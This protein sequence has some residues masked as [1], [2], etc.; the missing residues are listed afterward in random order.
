[1]DP[2]ERRLNWIE[3]TSIPNPSF[4]AHEKQHVLRSKQRSRN[5]IKALWMSTVLPLERRFSVSSMLVLRHD[6]HWSCFAK[7]R[8]MQMTHPAYNTMS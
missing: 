1:M 5:S 8:V 2:R 7:S 4:S 3:L 6:H